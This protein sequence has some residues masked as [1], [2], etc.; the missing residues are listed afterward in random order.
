MNARN[1]TMHRE[2]TSERWQEAAQSGWALPSDAECVRMLLREGYVDAFRAAHP[3]DGR[4][5]EAGAAKFTAHV[6]HPMYRIDYAFIS[7]GAAGAGLRLL[8]AAVDGSA[9]GS[10]HF[11]L[12]VDL[13]WASSDGARPRL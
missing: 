1:R 4:A 2:W 10:D 7:R 6:G 3:G 8:G 11:P 9:V 13:E 12:V 5:L